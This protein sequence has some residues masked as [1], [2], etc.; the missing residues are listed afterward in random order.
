MKILLSVAIFCIFIW[1]HAFAYQLSETDYDLLDRVE[2]RL[3]TM[4]ETDELLT[5][6][7]VE[8]LIEKTLERKLSERTTSLLE[9]ILDDL[10]YE[11]Y[12]GDY[13][14]TANFQS[15]E[16]CYE[17]EYFDELD[18]RC[19]YNDED[20]SYDN[21]E[22]FIWDDYRDESNFDYSD[23]AHTHTDENYYGY[24]WE[25]E[26]ILATYIISADTI[27]LISGKTDPKY[28]N[29]W[30]KFSAIIPE[31]MRTDFKKYMIFDDKNAG[32]AAHVTQDEQDHTKWNLTVNISAVYEW[33]DTL[34]KEGIA[35][36]IHEYA[37]VLTLNKTQMR[38]APM[39][40]DEG[41]YDRF[42]KNCQNRMV[43][44]WCLNADAYLDDRWW[45]C[46]CREW[47]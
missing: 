37:H 41:I 44:E 11:Y 30:N 35:T 24:E 23:Y 10:R 43:Q 22:D 20:Y 21:E 45:R 27:T 28:E 33:Q 15:E 38:Y 39:S 14:E 42:A 31:N 8:A 34:T 6:K 9:I 7:N 2:E 16:D 17:D 5:A 19:Y 18:Q 32:T 4:I 36:L 3:F 46:I 40:E 25:E 1:F 29:A 13:S 12:L 26:E 47:K